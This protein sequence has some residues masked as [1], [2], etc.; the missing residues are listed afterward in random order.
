MARANPQTYTSQMKIGELSKR[1][2]VQV[3]TIRFYER[4]RLL[5]APPRTST[6]YRC[7]VPRDVNVIRGI[8]QLQ[9]LG[10]TLREI[11]ELIDLHRSTSRCV[12]DKHAEPGGVQRM[13]ALTRRKLL[14][15]EEKSRLLRHVR[16]D[17]VQMLENLQTSVEMAC[18]VARQSSG[19]PACP[20]R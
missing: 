15:I 11:K 18:P 3:G 20:R 13:I 7:Y 2:G 14:V 8:R 4:R 6:G 19:A 1:A 10:F 9:E 12:V 16:R 5:K 17:L